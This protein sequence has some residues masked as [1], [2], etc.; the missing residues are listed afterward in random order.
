VKCLSPDDLNNVW[1]F[2]KVFFRR[3][4]EGGQDRESDPQEQEIR[5]DPHSMMASNVTCRKP[6]MLSTKFDLKQS[7]TSE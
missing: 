3:R 4:T 6:A 2:A 5:A 7:R 1:R